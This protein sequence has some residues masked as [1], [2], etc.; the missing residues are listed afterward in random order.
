MSGH[1]VK[2]RNEALARKD[3]RGTCVRVVDTGADGGL[4]TVALEACFCVWILA[5]AAA[6]VSIL[7]DGLEASISIGVGPLAAAGAV[8]VVPPVVEAGK[9]DDDEDDG[10]DAA[11]DAAA[12]VRLCN[13]KPV[14]TATGKLR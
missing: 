14:C 4:I 9:D 10:D 13:E 8:A 5:A 2:T 7:D 1:S 11:I 6:A 3:N 12:A